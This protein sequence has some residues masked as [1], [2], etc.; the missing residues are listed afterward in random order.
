ME[1]SVSSMRMK[2]SVLESEVGRLQIF[3]SCALV[4]GDPVMI[5]KR[6][7]S[8]PLNLRRVKNWGYLERNAG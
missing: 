4:R 3:A 7:R 8:V 5:D 6:R 2:T 1:S